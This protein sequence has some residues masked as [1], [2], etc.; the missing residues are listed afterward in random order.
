M[1]FCGGLVG[2]NDALQRRSRFRRD[3]P[4]DVLL[5]L[6]GASDVGDS[7]SSALVTGPLAATSTSE[8]IGGISASAIE[9]ISSDSIPGTV[10]QPTASSLELAITSGQAVPFP[11]NRPLPTS[12][13]LGW[14]NMT[15]AA[16]PVITVTTI[17][18]TIIDPQNP[19]TFKVEEYCSTIQYYPCHR[20]EHQDIPAVRMTTV[21][22]ECNA[23][24]INGENSVYLTLPAA[25]AAPSATDRFKHVG[26]SPQHGS[27]PFVASPVETGFHHPKPIVQAKPTK[28][29]YNPLPPVSEEDD[30]IDVTV[31]LNDNQPQVHPE[32]DFPKKP[33]V[34]APKA[35]INEP[36][37]ADQAHPASQFVGGYE[38]K[39]TILPAWNGLSEVPVV[40][41]TATMSFPIFGT[42]FLVFTFA[43]LLNSM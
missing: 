38:I 15:Q 33:Q 28:A 35:P 13:W 25:V 23:C 7:S 42:I 37:P 11:P 36:R 32:D 10:T 40:V 22:R 41:S 18:Y 21:Q 6:Y 24:G 20:C 1:L 31:R 34:E 12:G 5:T 4:S 2:T 9:P 16:N 30:S 17:T 39:T 8:I 43:L 3:A 29:H 26:N 14:N 27:E 19:S